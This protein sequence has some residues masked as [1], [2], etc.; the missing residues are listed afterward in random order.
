MNSHHLSI[1]ALKTLMNQDPASSANGHTD[2]GY[3]RGVLPSRV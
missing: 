2:A 3:H 1:D